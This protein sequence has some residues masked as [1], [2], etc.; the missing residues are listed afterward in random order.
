MYYHQATR[1]TYTPIPYVPCLRYSQPLPKTF[2]Q[3]C[4]DEAS[5]VRESSTALPQRP[6]ASERPFDSASR[7]LFQRWRRRSDSTQLSASDS[8]CFVDAPT[9]RFPRTDAK[10]SSES[11]SGPWNGSIPSPVVVSGRNASDVARLHQHGGTHGQMRTPPGSPCSQK[12]AYVRSNLPPRI[13]PERERCAS[14]TVAPSI[15]EVT[16]APNST[17]PAVSLL[18]DPLSS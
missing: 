2:E 12:P 9:S 6:P 4:L 7:K 10:A 15:W 16:D 5:Y 3:H 17:S 11:S 14:G 8:V 18:P 1:R 13:Q